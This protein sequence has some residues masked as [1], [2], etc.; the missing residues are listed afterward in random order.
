[1]KA[2]TRHFLSNRIDMPR[3]KL[4]NIAIYKALNKGSKLFR[5]AGFQ[6]ELPPREVYDNPTRRLYVSGMFKCGR[7]LWFELRS[8]GV[9]DEKPFDVLNDPDN[10]RTSHMGDIS[11]A[12]VVRL[13][14]L[15]GIE[16]YN[17]QKRISDF[18]NQM[19][20]KIDGMFKL[21]D[22][23][24]LLE[25]KALKHDKVV[26]LNKYGVRIAMPHYYEQMQTYMYHLNYLDQGYL[27]VLDSDTRQFYVEKVRQELTT[28][29]WV[30]HKAASILDAE[31][32][33]QVPEQ[34]IERDCF[35]CPAQTLC[36]KLDKQ[37]FEHLYDEYQAKQDAQH[38][39]VRKRR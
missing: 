17:Q 16:V 13:L 6:L 33:H 8:P 39:E 28:A 4:E 38:A 24:C 21:G 11:E 27:V 25:I 31:V 9:L 35:F 10:W 29:E 26:E 34:I 12:Y 15:G 20:G 14:N 36:K 37:H 1:M 7:L 32:V 23:E 5:E 30:Q 2:P 3:Q 19:S 18:D 22:I